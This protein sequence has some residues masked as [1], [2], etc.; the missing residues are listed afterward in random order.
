MLDQFRLDFKN[1]VKIINF[2]FPELPQKLSKFRIMDDDDEILFYSPPEKQQKNKRKANDEAL[3]PAG[4]IR[5]QLEQL[6]YD[7]KKVRQH[8]LEDYDKDECLIHV[9]LGKNTNK[10]T[11]VQEES[12][13]LVPKQ[14]SG[15]I[16]W[17][18]KLRYYPLNDLL[19]NMVSF[20]EILF[21]DL[22][23]NSLYILCQC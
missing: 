20:R 18:N 13:S 21:P 8:N 15:P 16:L 22:L 7:K 9:D 6:N 2:I 10:T 11:T 4:E 17:I 3:D 5:S 19:P 14:S 23:K 1:K 12:K